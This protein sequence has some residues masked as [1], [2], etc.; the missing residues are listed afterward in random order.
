MG[1]VHALVVLGLAVVMTNR[2]ARASVNTV[3]ANFVT[4]AAISTFLYPEFQ[5][6]YI[7]VSKLAGQV[8]VFWEMAAGNV[9]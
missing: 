1:L 2:P 3:F 8:E 9:L 4:F 7:F 6:V 5:A